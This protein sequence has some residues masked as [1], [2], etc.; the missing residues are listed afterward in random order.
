M[1]SRRGLFAAILATPT[2]AIP[3]PAPRIRI[4]LKGCERTAEKSLHTIRKRTY[5]ARITGPYLL[6]D[7]ANPQT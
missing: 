1:I 6:F 5:S 4:N 2:L 7:D 3:A